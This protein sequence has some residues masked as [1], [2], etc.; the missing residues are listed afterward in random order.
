MADQN[1]NRSDSEALERDP[2]HLALKRTAGRYHKLADHAPSMEEEVFR[3]K[4][5]DRL[6]GKEHI[7]TS[8]ETKKSLPIES[9]PAPQSGFFQ[10]NFHK[11]STFWAPGL[12]AVFTITVGL[13]VFLFR[14]QEE[15]KRWNEAFPK[16]VTQP[17][18]VTSPG[19][20]K[21][22]SRDEKPLPEM[23]SHEN[24]SGQSEQE[25]K[26]SRSLAEPSSLP[27]AKSMEEAIAPDAEI[28]HLS[29]DESQESEKLQ[30]ET[31][32][33]GAGQVEQPREAGNATAPQPASPQKSRAEGQSR[34]IARE[35]QKDA[36]MADSLKNA[37]APSLNE[38]QLLDRL[39][40]ATGVTEKITILLQLKAL[41]HIQG[42][43]EKVKEMEQQIRKLKEE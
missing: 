4:L 38:N 29:Q 5:Q 34:A 42:N 8:G 32:K 22:L 30:S 9:V 40:K 17:A 24:A 13:P 15:S 11:K 33:G 10:R 41:Y 27:E 26:I 18:E 35:K 12:A 1:K 14:N 25:K 31:F 28:E 23:E 6:S 2:L 43:E 16:K 19:R 21:E 20:E 36:S 37:P 39:S 3:K 7:E